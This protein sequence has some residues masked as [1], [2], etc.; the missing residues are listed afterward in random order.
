MPPSDVTALIQALEPLIRDPALA[1]AMGERAR[2][3]VTKH[4]SVQSEAEEIC[5]GLSARCSAGS[6]LNYKS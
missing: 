2:D 3:Y 1:E 5:R 6:R 4:F